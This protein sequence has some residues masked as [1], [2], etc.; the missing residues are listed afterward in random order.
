[1]ENQK[2]II[3]PQK[4]SRWDEVYR[5]FGIKVMPDTSL[6]YELEEFYPHHVITDGKVIGFFKRD[7][8]PFFE[9]ATWLEVEP[10]NI[11]LIL[12]RIQYIQPEQ[13]EYEGV[14]GWI[15]PLRESPFALSVEDV[16]AY[17]HNLMFWESMLPSDT[18]GPLLQR[19]AWITNKLYRLRGEQ[20]DSIVIMGDRGMHDLSITTDNTREI[21][22]YALGANPGSKKDPEHCLGVR[23]DKA[24]QIEALLEKAGQILREEYY[25]K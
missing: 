15:M 7:G 14:K 22:E 18:T 6:F 12:D 19:I 3:N 16:N 4:Q 20:R 13:A 11:A 5:E 8:Q 25:E 24:R 2:S 23:P 17:I 10:M 1:M 21:V 9:E